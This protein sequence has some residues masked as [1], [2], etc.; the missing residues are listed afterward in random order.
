MACLYPLLP[1]SIGHEC[2]G[3]AR[4]RTV[5]ISKQ[6]HWVSSLVL[7]QVMCSRRAVGHWQAPKVLYSLSTP[8]CGKTGKRSAY[9]RAKFR[10]FENGCSM[11]QPENVVVPG[12]ELA[13]LWQHRSK[14]RAVGG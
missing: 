9:G 12:A 2:T 10:S 14:Y 5:S 3:K 7:G 1:G 8:A 11:P 6:Q 13:A 4:R